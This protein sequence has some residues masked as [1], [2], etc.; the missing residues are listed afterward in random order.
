[1]PHGGTP[2]RDPY[3]CAAYIRIA[4]LERKHRQPFCSA[5]W[6]HLILAFGRFNRDEVSP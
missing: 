5:V 2:R 1:M 6:H 3:G 4:F